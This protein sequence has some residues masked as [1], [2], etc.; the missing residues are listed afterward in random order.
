MGTLFGDGRALDEIKKIVRDGKTDL[1]V[2]KASLKTLID[3]RPPDLRL[4]CESVLDAGELNGVAARGLALFD[5]PAIGRRLAQ[6]YRR[7]HPLDRPAVL[8]VLVSR[9]TFARE[10]LDNIGTGNRQVPRED[11]SAVLARQILNLKNEELSAKLTRVWGELRDSPA[12]KKQLIARLRTQY[13]PAAL[14]KADLP[15][16]RVVYQ[17]VCAQCHTLYG[18][19]GKIGPDL[20]GS[21][22]NNLEYLLE[23]MIDPSSVVSADYRMT[24]LTL[25]DGR[26]VS[27]IL[28]AENDRTLSLKTATETLNVE[29]KN[30]EER[31]P[32]TQ[33][34]MP[35]N[36]LQPLSEAQ[37]RDLIAYLMYPTQVPLAKESK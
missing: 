32:S 27:G 10:L 7:F 13:Q 35:D 21:Q 26:Q 6:T 16:G 30:I 1:G 3:A 34:M 28:A 37:V 17:K 4:L 36:L 19:G 23:N 15:Q 25:R 8:E 9:P 5:D 20:T 18:E 2:R 24:M 22:R 11:I 33:S 14:T 12:E 29:K 31:F